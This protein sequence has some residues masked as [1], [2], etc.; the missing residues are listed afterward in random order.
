LD[1]Q[2]LSDPSNP[3]YGTSP[4]PA[5]KN[6]FKLKS[7]LVEFRE[8]GKKGKDAEGEEEGDVVYI[9]QAGWERIVDW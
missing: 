5:R 6:D 2:G 9:A 1:R 8:T 7:N 3:F 4:P